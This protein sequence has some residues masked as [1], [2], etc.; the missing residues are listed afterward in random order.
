MGC[1][2]SQSSQDVREVDKLVALGKR[3]LV[4]TLSIDIGAKPVEVGRIESML[5]DE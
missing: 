1:I 2:S 3:K 4:P 5:M